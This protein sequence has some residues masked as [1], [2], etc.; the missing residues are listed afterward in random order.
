MLLML[1]LFSL[2]LLILLIF[3]FLLNVFSKPH[4]K[5]ERIVEQKF[6]YLEYYYLLVQETLEYHSVA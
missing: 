3:A 2:F 6:P 1:L 5:Y 4:Q